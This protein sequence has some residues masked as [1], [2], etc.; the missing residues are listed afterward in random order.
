[1][2]SGTSLRNSQDEIGIENF[3]KETLFVFE[4]EDEMN[5]KEREL[6]DAV[7]C[8]DPNTYNLTLGAGGGW[9]Y[10]NIN[11]KN[12]YGL[13]GKTPNVKDNLLR[14]LETQ[15]TL[16]KTNK[17]WSE[18]R[19]KRIS[20]ST[21]EYIAN[22]GAHFAGRTHSKE[23]KAAIGLK[24]SVHQL[25][26]NNSQY[27]TI[28]ISDGVKEKKISKDADIPCGWKVG[29]L[30]AHLTKIRNQKIKE[31]K[32]LD[33]ENEKQKK[34]SELKHLKNI[35]DEGGFKAV[36]EYGYKFSGSNLIQMFKR[37]EI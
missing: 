13:N 21:K 20:V 1:M 27:D 24:S 36:K 37:Y 29:R 17:E 31:V 26:E 19:R 28:W 16:N 22:N 30:I 8:D 4:T 35:Y 18:R 25:G 7:F 5:L 15:R 2:G 10:T 6:V 34:I 12:L 11:G 9:Y 3:H 14:G 33:N 23:T 32:F